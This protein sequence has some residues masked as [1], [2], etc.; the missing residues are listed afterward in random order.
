MRIHTEVGTEQTLI[1]ICLIGNTKVLSAEEVSS[2][3]CVDRVGISEE[4]RVLGG[5]SVSYRSGYQYGAGWWFA[6]FVVKRTARISGRYS[7][8]RD[9]YEKRAALVGRYQ[10]A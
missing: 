6:S 9:A 8:A 1:E 7:I 4:Y 3:P 10:A 5:T 2:L